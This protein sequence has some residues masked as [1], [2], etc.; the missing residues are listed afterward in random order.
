MLPNGMGKHGENKKK[1]T[2]T[3]PP[4]YVNLLNLWTA[5]GYIPNVS[6]GVRQALEIYMEAYPKLTDTELLEKKADQRK[7]LA[8]YGQK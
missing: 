1:I 8:D 3:L 5:A 4:G 7:K 2:I 6:D